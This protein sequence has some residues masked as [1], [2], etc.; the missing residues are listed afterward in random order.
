LQ[1]LML[2]GR[3]RVRSAGGREGPASRC[4]TLNPFP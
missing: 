2:C 3:L 1:A 4:A